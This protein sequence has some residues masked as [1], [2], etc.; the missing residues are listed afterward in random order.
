MK[1]PLFNSLAERFADHTVDVDPG[2]WSAISGKLAVAN[3]STL[4]ELL[5]DKFDGHEAHV[6]PQVWA[7]ISSQLGHGAAAGVGSTAGWW[8]AGIA[9]TLVAGGFLVYSLTGGPTAP[10]I[11]E[12]TPVTT[13]LVPEPQARPDA[14]TT[15]PLNPEGAPVTQESS[16]ASTLASTS[17][18]PAAPAV[19]KP[20]TKPAGEARHEDRSNE[21]QLPPPTPEGEQAVV[22]VLQDIVDNYV[23]SPIVVVTEKQ[24][25]PPSQSEMPS[26][27]VHP[28]PQAEAPEEP[29]EEEALTPELVPAPA[30]AV[31]IPT[32]FS[33]NGDDVN[34]VLI[35]NV[36]NYQKAHVRIFSATSNALVFASDNLEDKWN[37]RT[38]NTGPQCEPGMYFYA[39]E[40]TDQ[41]GRTWSKGEV[42]RLFR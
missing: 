37:G 30:L 41:D 28:E 15:S 22:T 5:Q 32:A 39:L 34:D 19:E 38:M 26:S 35:V 12:Q 3:G 25:P 20:R 29:A 7:N 31:L 21:K 40:V 1:D 11:A 9:A 36:R 14:G 13:S 2:T 17:G 24:V 6:D 8:A 42:V 27:A 10:A 18:Q 23:T 33:P 16:A 4:S